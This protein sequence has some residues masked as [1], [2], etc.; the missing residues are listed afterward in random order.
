MLEIDVQK[1]LRDFDLEV[2]LSIAGGEILM[3]V[4][5]NGCGKTTLLE[6]DSGLI[7]PDSGRI[8]LKGRSL[9]DSA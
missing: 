6:P 5:D 8:T 4:G 9:F 1:K 3:L 7:S 2:K